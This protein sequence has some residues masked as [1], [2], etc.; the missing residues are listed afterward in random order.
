MHIHTGRAEASTQD[1]SLGRSDRKPE[2]LLYTPTLV[3]NSSID[4]R[5]QPQ[6]AV[7]WFAVLEFRR[8]LPYRTLAIGCAKGPVEGG[9]QSDL[10]K[11]SIGARGSAIGRQVVMA[12]LGCSRS[13]LRAETR[14]DE[15][16]Q[17]EA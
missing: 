7:E 2:P 11:Q 8:S 5:A 6:I 12:R 4:R 14:K 13:L 3:A 15:T 17:M 9:R 1:T 16:H 10:P